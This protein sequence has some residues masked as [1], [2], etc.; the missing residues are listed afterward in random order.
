MDGVVRK[1]DDA[2]RAGAQAGPTPPTPGFVEPG[3][4]LLV[5]VDGAEGAFHGAT[6]ALG[7]AFLAE[8]GVAE[9]ADPRVEGAALAGV[10]DGLDGLHGGAHGVF[11][12]LLHVHGTA[13]GTGGIDAGA[14]GFVGEADEVGVHGSRA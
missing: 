2:H 11:H 1:G 10:L 6:L 14:A 9:V 7:A 5:L 12:G 4:F 3:V 13:H 8:A